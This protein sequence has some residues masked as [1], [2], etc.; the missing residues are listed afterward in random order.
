MKWVDTSFHLSYKAKMNMGIYAVKLLLQFYCVIY[1]KLDDTFRLN[2][3]IY[4]LM[5][6]LFKH[7]TF[8]DKLFFGKYIVMWYKLGNNILNWCNHQRLI[9]FRWKSVAI[10]SDIILSP[11]N[12]SNFK[13]MTSFSCEWVYCLQCL[14][15]QILND[16]QFSVCSPIDNQFSLISVAVNH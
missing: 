5:I 8:C 10:S 4:Q 15:F 12:T 7:P 11:N 16:G 6:N 9:P 2:K 1:C 13:Y 14:T 3:C